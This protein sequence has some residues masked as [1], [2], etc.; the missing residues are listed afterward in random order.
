MSS[1]I[2]ILVV[3]DHDE[4]RQ[5]LVNLLTQEED[6]EIIGEYANGKEALINAVVRSPD[7]ILMDIRMPILDGLEAANILGQKSVSCKVILLTM[8][9]EYLDEA[10]KS[11]VQG[12]L[13]KGMKIHD[14]TEAIR[15]VHQGEIV[16]DERI[17]SKVKMDLSRI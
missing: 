11:G 9:E 15:S 7:I 17:R 3:D 1:K 2:R 12:Y 13:L 10:I 8:Y 5:A 14:L 4:V 16:I 6:M